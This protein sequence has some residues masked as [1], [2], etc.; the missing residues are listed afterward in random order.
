MKRAAVI[1]LDSLGIGALPDAA[2]YGDVGTNT[3]LH[4]AQA[5][6]G[7]NLPRLEQLG[8]GNIIPVP[9][10]A[11]AV[12]PAASYG[13]MT[14][15]SAGKDT[16]TGHWELMG[17]V[18]EHPFPVY[19]HGF[20]PEIINPFEAAIGR[21]VLAN[22]AASGTE[23][24]V[25]LGEEHLRSGYPIVYTS[26]DS[27]FQIAA[28]EEVIPLEELYRYCRIARGLL[29]GPHAVGRVIARPFLGEPGH[30][31]RTAHRRDFA[32]EAPGP[33]LLDRL[34]AAGRDV[35]GIGKIED[36]FAGRGLTQSSHTEN[37]AD[38]MRQTLDC[39]RK[40]FTGLLFVN[41]VDYDSQ[42]GHRNDAQGYG[43]ALEE[44]DRGL[45][46]ILAALEEG[47]L[48][49]ITADHGCDPTTPGTDH[50]REYVPLL[51]YLA[52]SHDG[53]N[54]GTRESFCDLAATL[55]E[56][57][58]IQWPGPGKSFWGEISHV[59]R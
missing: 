18:L 22:K 43:R 33:T 3:L 14:E 42:F 28:H 39:L 48:L 47:D 27:V 57:F 26:A 23:I 54:L 37:N 40:P 58:Q 53:V 31:Y 36:I 6:G 50:T 20:P 55:A 19:P 30:F 35:I 21:P 59:S 16:T 7:L 10:V 24:I 8:L 17:V 45:K 15:V 2:D 5:V 51:A 13:R 12:G 41:L 32:L 4:V 56:A 34:K 44:F 9:G 29:T 1:I 38:G 52:G 46:E 11:A 49:I 25:E